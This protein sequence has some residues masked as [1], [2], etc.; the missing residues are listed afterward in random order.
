MMP[1]EVLQGKGFQAEVTNGRDG[2]VLV[3]SDTSSTFPVNQSQ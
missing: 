2:E 1:I 3:I